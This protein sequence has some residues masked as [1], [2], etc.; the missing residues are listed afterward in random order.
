MLNNLGRAVFN[1]E[2]K[3]TANLWFKD[4]VNF[5]NMGETNR[6]IRDSFWGRITYHVSGHKY[7]YHKEESPDYIIPDK[8]LIDSKKEGTNSV[9]V[10][11]TS[12][13]RN[14]SGNSTNSND[15]NE[16]LH[17]DNRIVVDWDGVDDPENPKNWSLFEKSIVVFQ[18]CLLT[19]VVYMSSAIFTPGV[20]QIMEELH[21][22]RVKA[23]VPLTTFVIGY[24]I[25]PMFLSPMSENAVFGRTYIYIVTLFIFFILQ[26]PISLVNDITSLSI[27]RFFSGIF[28]SPCLAT[29]GA[30]MG[31]ITPKAYLPITI[32]IWSISACAGPALGPL[33]GS[34]MVVKRNWHWTFW[35]VSMTS[36]ILLVTFGFCLPETY[37]KTLLLRKAKRLRKVT[38]N[39]N[40][41]SEGEIENEG[42][43]VRQ[44]A[45]E[46]LWRPIEI[47]L[48]E[49]VVLLIDLYIALVY[50]ILYIWFEGF[51]IAYMGTYNFTLITMGATFITVAIG[52]NLGACVYV[53]YTYKWFTIPLNNNVKVHP[54][55]FLPIMIV[56][57]IFLP[58]G[59][60]IFGWTVNPN[61]HWFGSLVGG[62]LF[63]VGAFV[64]FQSS[65][66]YLADSFPDY[67][68]SVFAGND[69]LRSVI[70]SVFPLFGHALFDNLAID[71]YP[72]AWGSSVLGFISIGMILIPILFYLNGPKLRARSKYAETDL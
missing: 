21:I 15:S 13:K 62:A 1:R 36:G 40:I 68:A 64:V 7:F 46:T 55:V 26:I 37:E 47:T 5:S 60:L 59:V 65:F 23:T 50:S 57:S 33:I 53:L 70:A 66:L 42:L 41:T 44:V 4:I 16:T 30:S 27:L 54:E 20:D 25:G 58:T 38:G 8:Y 6:F 24:G 67:L 31:D 49:P 63:G 10:R 17:N 35:F 51:P 39:P 28:A 69:L 45:I 61:V 14:D 22:T 2:Y 19:A 12:P 71:N 18:I 9:E 34:I 72:V 11:P 3:L 32:A 52:V 56:G 43:T 29:G 48:F